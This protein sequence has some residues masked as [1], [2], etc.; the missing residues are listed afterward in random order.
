MQNKFTQK[1]NKIIL[2]YNKQKNNNKI[3][4]PLKEKKRPNVPHFFT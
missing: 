2:L 3:S 1:K 4:Q